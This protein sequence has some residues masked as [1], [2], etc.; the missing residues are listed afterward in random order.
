M[1]LPPGF[2]LEEPSGVNLPEGFVL[3][4]APAAPQNWWTTARPYVEPAVEALGGLAGGV[5]GAPLGPAGAIAGGAMGYALGRGAMR[6]GDI[7]FAPQT[8]PVT[9]NEATINALRDV[10]TGGVMEAGGGLAGRLLGY[11]VNQ[12]G[13]FLGG[14]ADFNPTA[15]AAR[16]MQEAAGPDLAR[17]RA[18]A[19]AA[20]PDLL[21]GQATADIYRPEWQSLLQRSLARAPA[22][23]GGVRQAQGAADLN[24]LA[25]IAGGGT[26]TEA[27]AAREATTQGVRQQLIPQR[28][29]EL[30]TANIAGRELPRLDGEA[31]RLGEAAA[32]KVE[33]VRRFTAAGERAAERAR[34]DMIAK[35]LPVAGARYSYMGGDLAQKAEEV[36]ASAASGSLLFGEASRFAQRAADSLAAHGLKPLKS[37][38]IRQALLKQLRDPELAGNK[39]VNAAVQNVMDDIARWTNNGGVIDAFA[40]DAIRKNSINTA[41]QSSGLDPTA[42]KKAMSA[43]LLRVR[44]IID[45]AIEAAGGTGYKKYLQDYAAAMA[46]VNQAELGATAMKLYKESPKKFVQ[47]VEGEAPD[48]VEKILGPGR[49]DIAA[50]LSANTMSTL[51]DAA[52]TITREQAVKEQAQAGNDLLAE[53]MRSSMFRGRLPPFL[54]AKI[55]LANRTL[56]ELEDR[57]G[58]KTLDVLTEAAKSGGNAEKIL[59][60][61]K[62]TDRNA[63]LRYLTDPNNYISATAGR[64]AAYGVNALSSQ[65]SNNTLAR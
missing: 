14:V 15:R 58:K 35:G 63:I 6:G 62:A 43:A 24:L 60:R 59:S 33:D 30:E 32:A 51:K 41:I 2:V 55:T 13:R 45:N 19:Q 9:G 36:A 22:Y 64:G 26:A 46:E 48:K 52:K 38:A 3:E 16:I 42:Q 54:S 5:V 31:Q 18:A 25:R 57:L 21:A 37:D 23:E 34:Q 65:E 27:R 56:D 47:M 29:I 4:S 7:A 11:G 40:L 39:P 17:I 12:A 53:I 10:V 44:P 49:Y 20:P 8:M 61:M 1:P 28:D 50:E